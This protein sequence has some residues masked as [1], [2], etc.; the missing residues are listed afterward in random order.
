[1]RLQEQ[2]TKI[3]SIMGLNESEKNLSDKIEIFLN[4]T[5][6]E[7]RKD[8]LC[9]VKVTHPEDREVLPRQLKYQYYSITLY[10]IGGPNTKYWPR[11]QKVIRLYDELAD[12]AW[13]LVHYYMNISAQM[14]YVQVPSCDDKRVKDRKPKTLGL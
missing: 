5:L 4:K 1:M 3:Q 9:G 6:V 14:Y 2:I 7:K 8:I 11:T 12:E 10:V 13:E